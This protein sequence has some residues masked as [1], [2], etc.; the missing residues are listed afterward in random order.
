MPKVDLYAWAAPATIGGSKVDHTWTTSFD[1]RIHNYPDIAAVIRAGEDFWFCWG[2]YRSRG[3]TPANKTGFLGK[4]S[5]D[6]GL[7]RCLVAPNLDSFKHKAARG[8]I[9]AYGVDGV[10]H[11]VSNQALYATGP[12]PLTVKLARGYY[13]SVFLYGT[14]GRSA[15]S[16]KRKIQAC[17][18]GGKGG[19]GGTSG[20]GDPDAM[21]DDFDQRAR[22]VLGHEPELLAQLQ[23]LKEKARKPVDRDTLPKE[24]ARRAAVLNAQ[25]QAFLDQ[26][27][28]LLG[29]RFEQVFGYPAEDRI[30]LVDPSI[31]AKETDEEEGGT[32]LPA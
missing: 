9:F 17:A 23:A 20:S 4:K 13:A 8:T 26:A 15:S 16:W 30:V 28:V 19:G 2:M 7:A 24:P 12:S 29:E 3:G 25:N 32:P 5:G 10:C 11:Q 27:A 31:M 22:E 21:P 6:L 14:Y 18:G 1:N